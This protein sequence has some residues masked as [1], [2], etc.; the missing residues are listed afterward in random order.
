MFYLSAL[1]RA[2][3]LIEQVLRI[4]PK[5]PVLTHPVPKSTSFSARTIDSNISYSMSNPSVPR[6]HHPATSPSLNSINQQQQLPYMDT[7]S[8]GRTAAKSVG[9]MPVLRT[10]QSTAASRMTLGTTQEKSGFKPIEQQRPT[11]ISDTTPRP[12]PIHLPTAHYGVT[13]GNNLVSR[14]VL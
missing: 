1:C 12:T 3:L 2:D 10:S 9:P 8:N 7:L 6:F 4:D 13:E 11:T 5:L 14:K